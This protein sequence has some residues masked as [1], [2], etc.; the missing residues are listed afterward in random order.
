MSYRNFEQVKPRDG[1][2]V[3]AFTTL[4][5]VWVLLNYRD[6]GYSTIEWSESPDHS[7][8]RLEVTFPTF[9]CWLPLSEPP[10]GFLRYIQRKKDLWGTVE[11]LLV[12]S[13]VLVL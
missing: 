12:D 8:A 1:Q 4:A 6:H 13:N 11:P 9:T 3:W 5:K 10:D 7:T 2:R